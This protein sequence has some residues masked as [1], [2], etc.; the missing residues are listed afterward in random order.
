MPWYRITVHLKKG[1]PKRGIRH[2][3][4]PYP[5]WEK[6]VQQAAEKAFGADNI[7]ELLIMRLPDDHP[8][9]KRRKGKG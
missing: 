7:R 2:S 5:Q 1:V 4:L 6:Y 9:V 8:E 3:T